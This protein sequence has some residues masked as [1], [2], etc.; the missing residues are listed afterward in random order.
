MR[1]LL[2][3]SLALLA[4]ACSKGST[5][6]TTVT[7]PPPLPTPAITSFTASP[8]DIAVGGASTLTWTTTGAVAS[9]SLSDGTN[10]PVDVTGTLT[11]LMSPTLSTTY[12]LTATNSGG[13]DSRQVSI[14]VHAPGLRLQYTDPAS[15]TA[16]ILVVKSALS[17][18]TNLVLDVKVGAAPITAFGFAM[19]IPLVRV[20]PADPATNGP[21]AADP[22]QSPPGLKQG[23]INMGASPVTGAVMVGG[24]AMQKFISVGVARHTATLADGD[25]T[26]AAGSTLFSV[27][28]KMVGTPGTGDVFIGSAVAAD[29][30]FRAAALHKDGTEAVGKSDI[31]LGDFTITL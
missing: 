17:T 15:A 7:V 4:V 27:A 12:T 3:V 6:P 31:A 29:P 24:A 19:S 10:P 13:S 26:W 30:T 1:R 9:L 20:I 21:F 5:P 25:D 28:L 2:P 18:P 16:K 11:R 14:S 8:T 23:I 22:S